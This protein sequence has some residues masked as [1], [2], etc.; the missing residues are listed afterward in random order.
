MQAT[1]FIARQHAMHADRDIVLPSLYVCLTN[2]V[3]C[4]KELTHRHILL[5]FR[6]G[7]VGVY[8]NPPP[9]LRNSKGNPQLGR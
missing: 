3:L 8:S 4:Q 9:P 2:A 7:I 6:Q 5:T 1:V